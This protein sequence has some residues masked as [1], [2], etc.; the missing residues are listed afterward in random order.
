M[1]NTKITTNSGFTQID[2]DLFYVQSVVS[3][4]AFSLLI[5]IYR[6]T[7]GYGVSVKALSGTYLQKTTNLS[8]NTITKAIKE[9][10][11][12]GVLLVRRR[13]RLS[14]FYQ[15]SS[16]GVSKVCNS[17]KSSLANF[18]HSLEDDSDIVEDDVPQVTQVTDFTDCK[19]E[20]LED[21][22][23]DI[24]WNIYDK[25]VGRLECKAAWD[26]IS[27]KERMKIM[28][29]LEDYVTST[30][31]KKYRKDPINYLKNKVWQDEIL[32]QTTTKQPV[33]ENKPKLD[34]QNQ[35]MEARDVVKLGT[36]ADAKINDFLKRYGRKGAA[37]C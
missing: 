18:P 12:L 8:K 34:F 30:P 35:K 13:A 37:Y 7:L 20:T 14:S 4:S 31:D 17:I 16:K 29:N 5:R 27:K 24:F 28:T 36:E 25:K 9:L 6:A 26:K 32:I 23:F 21:N 33:F 15:V 22:G 11:E 1:S 19:K 3:P 2:N 10:E